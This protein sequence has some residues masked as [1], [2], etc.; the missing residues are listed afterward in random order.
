MACWCSIFCAVSASNLCCTTLP[1]QH[2]MILWWD[3]FVNLHSYT[4]NCKASALPLAQGFRLVTPDYLPLWDRS[5]NETNSTV[6]FL[7]GL[8]VEG[9]T[10]RVWRWDK[11]HAPISVLAYQCHLSVYETMNIQYPSSGLKRQPLWGK[12]S[13]QLTKEP[14]ILPRKQKICKFKGIWCKVHE[15]VSSMKA[16]TGSFLTITENL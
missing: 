14:P 6:P 1:L 7:W 11:L 12:L 4:Y 15:L 5:G 16:N 10:W 2:L 13:S 3:S 9:G 8:H